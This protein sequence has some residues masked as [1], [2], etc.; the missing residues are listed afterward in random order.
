MPKQESSDSSGSNAFPF[1]SLPDEVKDKIFGYFIKTHTDRIALSRV[2]KE[3][4]TRAGRFGV[5]DQIWYGLKSKERLTSQLKPWDLGLIEDGQ[6]QEGPC[7]EIGRTLVRHLENNFS[8]LPATMLGVLYTECG[9]ILITFSGTLSQYTTEG[10]EKRKALIDA[11]SK[12]LRNAALVVTAGSAGVIAPSGRGG[13]HLRGD[14]V[15]N[16]RLEKL[17]GEF[18]PAGIVDGETALTIPGTCALPKLIAKCQEERV[19]PRWVSEIRF[20]PKGG[21]VRV[22]GPG[23]VQEYVHGNSV[24]SCLNCR[25]LVPRMLVGLSEF[26]SGLQSEQERSE[27]FRK[28]AEERAA[29]CF[30]LEEQGRAEQMEYE[31]TCRLLVLGFVVCKLGTD[32]LLSWIE[33]AFR[34]RTADICAAV[35]SLEKHMTKELIGDVFAKKFI[36]NLRGRVLR[37]LFEKWEL[38]KGK[39]KGKKQRSGL[40][41]GD[42]ANEFDG[43]FPKD[44]QSKID[45]S[46][47][48]SHIRDGDGPLNH[49]IEFQ[50]LAKEM[51]DFVDAA[52]DAAC[53][54]RK[55]QQDWNPKDLE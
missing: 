39:G 4:R 9:K 43:L 33:S 54:P 21:S 12:V 31:E 2:S 7:G 52:L 29:R 46:K 25:E 1:D 5:T 22:F 53:D 40:S 49:C 15:F 24:P 23:G 34:T 20:S 6:F 32:D 38:A 47:V 11:N 19:V 28:F 36:Q 14:T 51:K 26:R 18:M 13:E 10:K 42:R 37:W 35:T 48:I 55:G 27:R 17:G 3:W 16:F 41:Q 45:L 50:D 30:Q 44:S 8:R